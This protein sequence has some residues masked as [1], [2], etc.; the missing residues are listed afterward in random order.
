MWIKRLFLRGF[1]N[2]EQ[3]SLDLKSGFN[4][5]VGDNA[6]GKTNLLEAMYVLSVG[7]SFRAQR[8]QEL[9]MAGKGAAQLAAIVH[10]DA[11]IRLD[12]RIAEDSPKKLL[13]NSKNTTSRYFSGKLNVVLFTPDDLQLV[14]GSPAGRRR[15]LDEEISQVSA[16]YSG[17]VSQYQ[18]ILHQRNRIL[19]DAAAG[20][21]DRS[22]LEVFDQQLV[23][24]GSRIMAKR[25][26]AVHKLS[27][28]S[29]LMHRKIT[30]GEEEFILEYVPFFSKQC[31]TKPTVLSLESLQ[32]SFS[33]ALED[34]REL[35]LKRGY[36]L[37][38]PQ[39][40]DLI[41]FIDGLDA[42]T[43]GSQGQQRTAVL[44]CRMAEM[45]FMRSETG[46]YP[47]VLLDDVMSELDYKRRQ[48][49]MNILSDNV[50]T[51]ITTT[52]LRSF[53]AS[54]RSSSQVLRIYRGTVQAE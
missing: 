14:K 31:S 48:F 27:L 4:I 5:F 35:E 15:F 9:I 1:R 38:G 22:L 23:S 42:R 36:S 6:Q 34:N 20:R 18:T 8:D 49:L 51:V 46:S 41:F 12:V 30:D 13:L 28:L 45:Q 16:V 54:M 7:R 39:R 17:L 52:N 40:D 32:E 50:Q 10:R 47:V 44:S 21:R 29:R 25:S 24:V 2:Y 3:L 43:Y 19:K 11:D 26:D 33:H 37:V 53:D